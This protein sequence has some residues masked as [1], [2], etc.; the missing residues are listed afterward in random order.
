M[1]RP[2]R[3]AE[4][5]P[6]PIGVVW[7]QGSIPVLARPLKK[8]PLFVRLPYAPDNRAWLQ[9]SGR[10][11]P[12]KARSEKTG[13]VHW[14][15]PIAWFAQLIRRCVDRYGRVYVIQPINRA[16]KCAGSCWNAL[17]EICECSCLGTNHGGG[18]PAGAWKEISEAFAVLWSGAELACRLIE[19]PRDS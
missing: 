18:R 14:E 17:W 3:V 4:G 5:L 16:E 7:R 6:R 2:P 9:Q 19:R 1:N 15:V 12:K 8:S 13:A 10:I 11:H